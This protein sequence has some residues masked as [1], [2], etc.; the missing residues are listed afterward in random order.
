MHY[1]THCV[2]YGIVFDPERFHF[3]E[4]G[5][6]FAGFHITEDGIKP[7]KRMTETFL[8]FPSPKN[9]TNFRSWFGLVNQDSYAFSQTEIIAPFRKL[10][11]TKE[12][13]FYWNNIL[14][15]IFYKSKQRIARE[16]ED[17]MKTFEVNRPTCLSTDFSRTEVG[18]FLR[19]KHCYCAIEAGS[20]CGED[21]RKVILAG[22]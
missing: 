8:Q 17:G 9:V 6:Y 16:I 18:Y 12:R 21:H 3:T 7:T 1:I 14:K 2:D 4:K 15:Q 11:R 19:Q 22:S 10:L 20:I 13:K 5:V